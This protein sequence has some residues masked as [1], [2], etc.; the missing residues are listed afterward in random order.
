MG[1][2]LQSSL[3]KRSTQDW[4]SLKPVLPVEGIL[5]LLE[6]QL[7]LV[8]LLNKDAHSESQELEP[9]AMLPEED[10]SYTFP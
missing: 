2:K 4:G 1:S 6:S 8:P 5:G 3:V 9:S 10:V 7:V